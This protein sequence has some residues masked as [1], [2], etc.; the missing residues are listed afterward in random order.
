VGAPARPAISV[1]I[2]V[3]NG[4]PRYVAVIE[5][6]SAQRVRDSGD[7]SGVEILVADSGSKDGATEEVARRFPHV[8]LFDVFPDEFD[9]GR[10]RTGLALAAHAPLVAILSADALP[11]HDDYLERLAGAFDDPEVAGVYAR[12]VP[13]PSADPLVV[14]ALA[15]WTPS[16]EELGEGPHVRDA[17]AGDW[18]DDASPADAMRAARLDNV[19]SMVRRDVVLAFPF[20]PRTFGEDVS[21]ARLVAQA[22]R[23]L[24]YAPQARVEHHH[25]PTVAELF[26]RNRRAHRQVAAEF[27]VRAVPSTVAGF[28]ALAADTVAVT[29]RHGPVWAARTLPRRAAALAG[30]WVGRREA[31]WRGPTGPVFEVGHTA[32]GDAE[33]PLAVVM[34]AVGGSPHLAPALKTIVGLPG[35]KAPPVFVVSEADPG[36]A[37]GLDVRWVRVEEGAGYACRANAGFEAAERAGIPRVVLL[38]DDVAVLRDALER[39]AA[40][41]DDPTVGIAGAVLLEWDDDTVQ[42][43]GIRVGFSGRIRVL[44]EAPT[45]GHPED[46]DALSGAAMALSTAIWRRLGGF[47]VGYSH[48]FEDIDLC[49]RARAL[50]LR[51]VLVPEAR[52]RHRGGGTRGHAAPATARLLGRNH[53]RFASRLPGG[54]TERSLRLL[55]VAGLGLGWSALRSGPSGVSAFAAGF[56]AGVRAGRE[57]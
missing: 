26:S 52:I 56:V 21:W 32:L 41:L 6:L 10:V 53:A 33:E 1:V 11:L 44:D 8:R 15:R 57:R 2:P 29:R 5:A 51:S 38:N 17:P 50:G 23:R 3:L 7:R 4:G 46:R 12:Q 31:D 22:G 39:L 19:A 54:W 30:Q 40:A 20:P 55:S 16:A 18:W 49:L 48:F 14:A 36:E 27:G 47:D 13:G 42:H 35:A 25:D 28:V 45:G 34:P 24:G 37:E 43:G 9:H